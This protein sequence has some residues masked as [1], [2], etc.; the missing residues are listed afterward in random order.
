MVIDDI[1]RAKKKI[2]KEKNPNLDLMEDYFTKMYLMSTENLAGYL[3]YYNFKDKCVLTTGSSSDQILNLINYGCLNIDHFDIN[4]FVKYY[5][6]L[7]KNA[8]LTLGLKKYLQFFNLET[9]LDKSEILNERTYYKLSKLLDNDSKLFWDSLYNDFTP[10]EIC[11]RLFFD[12]FMS[13]ENA[14][15]NN[16]YLL[17]NNFKDL[18]KKIEKANVNFMN[19]NITDLKKT[20]KKYDYVMLSN[21]LDY[22]FKL[23]SMFNTIEIIE[24]LEEYKKFLIT[25][26]SLLNDDGIMF[27]HYFW[28][29]EHNYL[30]YR[31]INYFEDNKDIYSRSFPNCDKKQYD[32]S[33]MILQKTKS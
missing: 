9:P 17:D 11:E 26:T 29:I 23:N 31:M 28:E 13:N 27:F 32:D 21:I 12:E 30:Y 18:S 5:Y 33:V 25:L 2:L 6:D 7:K 24:V 19:I 3:K 10:I 1:K 16:K 22:V 4:P 14:K 20:K 8:I 15:L